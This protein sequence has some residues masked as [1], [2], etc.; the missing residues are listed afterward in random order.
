MR[1]YLIEIKWALIFILVSLIWMGFEKIMGWHDS[2]IAKHPIYTNFFAIPA[3]LIYVFALLDK[4]NNYYNGYMNWIQGMICGAI[5]SFIVAIASPLTQ[6]IV[7]KII[8]P[9]Y[10]DNAI[11]YVVEL[12]K[13]SERQ[14]AD[15]FN[16]KAYMAQSAIST[17]GLGFFTSAIVS[18]FIRRKPTN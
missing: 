7:H 13:M 18:L 3:I 11:N 14:A 10:F 6:L 5:I 16:L 8:S 15:Y 1:K 2:Q 9:S 17:L 12:G 4:R